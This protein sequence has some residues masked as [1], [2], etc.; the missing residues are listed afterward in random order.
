MSFSRSGS[1]SRLRLRVIR[2]VQK[3]LSTRGHEGL[4][5]AAKG[6]EEVQEGSATGRKGSEGLQFRFHSLHQGFQGG[7]SE[8]EGG[9]GSAEELR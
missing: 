6:F 8:V 1:A 2:N 4:R 9:S 7:G 5:R 3:E